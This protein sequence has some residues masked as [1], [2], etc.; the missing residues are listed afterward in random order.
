MALKNNERRWGLEVQVFVERARRKIEAKRK[1]EKE[2]AEKEE[3]M[4][5]R[6]RKKKQ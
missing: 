2:R 3:Q 1:E 4:A 5:I 6:G